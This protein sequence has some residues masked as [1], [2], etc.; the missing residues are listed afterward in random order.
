MTL[1]IS[2]NVSDV[3]RIAE[4]IFRSFIVDTAEIPGRTKKIQAISKQE[5]KVS[6]ECDFNQPE[7]GL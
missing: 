2:R 1:A 7:L 5:M 6:Q 3:R 4:R